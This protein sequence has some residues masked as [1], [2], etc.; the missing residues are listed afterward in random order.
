MKAW[1]E[2]KGSGQASRE[3]DGDRELPGNGV[4]GAQWWIGGVVEVLL[5]ALG[6]TSQTRLESDS[7]CLLNYN[8]LF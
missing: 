8:Q 2:G 3:M 6:T 7:S 1:T 5:S 4:I